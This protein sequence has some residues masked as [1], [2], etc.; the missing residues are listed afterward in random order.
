[1]YL[2]NCRCGY[3]VTTLGVDAV[4]ELINRG[5]CPDVVRNL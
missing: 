2:N 4:E 5:P 3:V 1:M